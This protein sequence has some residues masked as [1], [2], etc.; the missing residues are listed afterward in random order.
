MSWTNTHS[1][2]SQRCVCSIR[3][4]KLPNPHIMG[5]VGGNYLSDCDGRGGP[6]FKAAFPKHATIRARRWKGQAC[7]RLI[8]RPSWVERPSNRQCGCA[9]KTS[10]DIGEFRRCHTHRCFG[11]VSTCPKYYFRNVWNSATPRTKFLVTKPLQLREGG[12]T[13]TGKL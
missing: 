5:N 13:K 9:F 3:Q 4:Q 6:R 8:D 1:Q 7:C 11:F 12:A 2:N 10:D